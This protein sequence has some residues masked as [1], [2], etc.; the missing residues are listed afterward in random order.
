MRQAELGMPLD[1]CA[2]VYV[3]QGTK[4]DPTLTR[5]DR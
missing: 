1:V 4:I 5:A 2:P 3:V